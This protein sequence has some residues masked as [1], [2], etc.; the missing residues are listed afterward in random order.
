M[1]EL[2][3]H[4]GVLIERNPT[5]KEAVQKPEFRDARFPKMKR[6]YYSVRTGKNPNSG[7]IDLDTLKAMFRL[8]YKEFEAAG[9]FQEHFGYEC[10]DAGSV[11]GKL[12]PDISVQI[13][14]GLRKTNL[15]PIHEW[16][17]HYSEEDLFDVI[18][19][20]FDHISKPLEGWYHQF[21]N[22]GYHYEKFDARMGQAEYEL[23]AEVGDGVKG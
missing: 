11:S 18:E 10:V 8:L 9:Y 21:S 17:Q 15:W 16:L 22:C 14:F 7:P 12:G 20:L 23:W 19:F 6:R 2:E 5:V 1:A 4:F 3:V 13:H